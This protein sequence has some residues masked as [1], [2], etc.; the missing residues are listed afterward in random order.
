LIAIFLNVLI[1]TVIL[2]YISENTF[3]LKNYS[4]VF[5]YSFFYILGNIFLIKNLF[6]GS[7][8]KYFA[9]K[10]FYGISLLISLV[11]LLNITS[12]I[13]LVFPFVGFLWFIFVYSFNWKTY[14]GNGEL[15]EFYKLG[16]SGF[17]INAALGFSF[18]IDKYIV[19]HL[20][21]LD[22]A[23]AYTFA[24][25][26]TSPMLYLGSMIEHSMFASSSG[27]KRRIVFF[28]TF[29]LS[30]LVLLYGILSFSV[31]SHFPNFVPKTVNYTTFKS[32]LVIFLV[33]YSFYTL[34]Q[35]P[36]NGILFKFIGSEA[37][38][39]LAKVYPILFIFFAGILFFIFSINLNQNYYLL[40]TL[41]AGY[42][43]FLLIIKA[44]VIGRNIKVASYN[45]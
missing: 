6:E 39:K 27:E 22:T 7:Y 42:L 34:I 10:L 16:F 28:S 11:V 17:I 20:F 3:N 32:I 9:Y 29:M 30:A 4:A 13:F 5:V 37:Q 36:L 41:N 44:F 19:N 26:I 24:W 21:D 15:K 1:T 25:A 33:V 14:K 31:I 45:H 12:E 38:F 35:F 8:K 2:F 43:F 18:I 40:I 23:N